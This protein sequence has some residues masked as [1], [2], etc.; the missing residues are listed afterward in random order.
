MVQTYT[1][2]DAKT[3]MPTWAQDGSRCISFF[4]FNTQVHMHAYGDAAAD[5]DATA[6]LDAALVAARD[7]CLF[8]E[9]AFSRTRDDSDIA[10]AHAASPSAVPV[11]PQTARLVRQALG[12]CERSRGKFDITMGT[13]TS[14]WNFHTG[15]VPSRL[16][17]ARALPHV[18]YRHIVLDEEPCGREPLDEEPLGKDSPVQGSLDDDALNAGTS[19]APSSNVPSSKSSQPALAITDPHTILDLGGVAK[20]YIADDLA[21]LFIAHGVGRF[22]IN[23]G[24]NV[25]VR[26]GRPADASARPPVAA[27]SPW[28]IGII[29]PLDPAHNRAIVDMVD[30][31]VVTSGIHERRFT[32]GGVTYHHILDPATGMPAK[33]DLTSA[34]IIAPRS[35]DCD[36]YSTTALML[37]ARDAIDFVESL[38]GIEA[39]LIDEV[40][41][42]WWTSGIEERLSLV[43]TLP[44]F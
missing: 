44:R 5:P 22:V 2:G 9:R 42:V 18:D 26:G 36:G 35:M 17:L 25:V 11:S 12:Y 39:V 34:T 6:R 1:Y 14:L 31:S 13:V 16:A 41:E 32:K 3:A 40:D 15:E 28:R 24:G 38:P 37:G 19:R 27:G 23:L 33:T 43:P 29:N 8:F 10:R 21:D 20:G 4:L 30:G 7:R